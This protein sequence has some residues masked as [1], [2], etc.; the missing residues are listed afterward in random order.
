MVRN[1]IVCAALV[2]VI[3]GWASADEG[4]T[5]DAPMELTWAQLVPQRAAPK[6]SNRTFFLGAP[7]KSSEDPAPPLLPEG[8]FMSMKRSQPGGDAPPAVVTELN[9]KRVKIGG[10]VVPLDFD[11]TSIKEF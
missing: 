1:P 6:A 5:A 7:S 3:A 2:A 11:A 8:N 4:R 10:Y 9:G